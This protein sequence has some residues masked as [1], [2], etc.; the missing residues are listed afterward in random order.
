MYSLEVTVT[1]LA[2]HSLTPLMYKCR[3]LNN[4]GALL[5]LLITHEAIQVVY[6][7]YML[8]PCVE[9]YGMLNFNT[10]V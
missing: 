7:H 5:V 9:C 1:C 6:C 3:I 2:S 4:A 10:F 8:T